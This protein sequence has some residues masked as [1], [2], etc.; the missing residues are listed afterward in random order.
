MATRSRIGIEQPDGKIRSI[1][2]HWDGYPSHNGRILLESYKDRDKILELMEI[3]DISSLADRVKP[4]PGRAHTFNDPQDG[5]C[6]SYRRDRCESGCESII[7]ESIDELAEA[8]DWC[9]YVY[10][11]ANG[12]WSVS[13]HSSGLKRFTCLNEIL[14]N[15]NNFTE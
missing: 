13:E 8:A 6:V 3:G 4:D 11:F 2:C 14:K 10:V 5:V 1:Y 9:E 12:E 7:S 15:K